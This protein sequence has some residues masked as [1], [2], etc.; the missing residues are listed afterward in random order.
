MG[1]LQLH[2][3]TMQPLGSDVGA[4]VTTFRLFVHAL[5][6][7]LREHSTGEMTVGDTPWHRCNRD[8]Y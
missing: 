6:I 5:P 1:A 7:G 3:S 8:R 2:T 4:N